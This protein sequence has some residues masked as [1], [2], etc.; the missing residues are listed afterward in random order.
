AHGADSS[1]SPAC[2][3]PSSVSFRPDRF[4]SLQSQT[5]STSPWAWTFKHISESTRPSTRV[6]RVRTFALKACVL[7]LSEIPE[8]GG[9]NLSTPLL[10]GRTHV[11]L[12]P[13]DIS[14][15]LPAEEPEHVVDGGLHRLPPL[16]WDRPGDMRRHDDVREF[17][18]RPV[19]R[20]TAIR[21]RIGPPH[22]E[23][24]AERGMGPEVV[25]QGVLDDQLPAGDVHE[26]GVRFHR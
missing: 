10:R 24:R 16:G 21:I 18:E 20:P 12:R 3:R 23:G 17:V 9:E 7:I 25:E 26:D 13:D 19:E 14:G 1:G 8:S 11:L 15:R 2:R 6:P 4:A 22:V 5:D